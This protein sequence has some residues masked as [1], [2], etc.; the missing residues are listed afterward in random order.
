MRLTSFDIKVSPETDGY[1]HIRIHPRAATCLGRALWHGARSAFEHPRHGS[2]Q[3]MEAYWQW[4]R[5]GKQHDHLRNFHGE[6]AFSVGVR[7]ET[8]PCMNF[9]RQITEGLHHRITQSKRV[10][11]LMLMGDVPFLQYND[12][13]NVGDYLVIHRWDWYIKSLDSIRRSLHK[14]HGQATQP[15]DFK[16]PQIT[17]ESIKG[18]TIAKP[19]P[20]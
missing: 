17:Q 10:V 18:Y 2:F 4:L 5:T 3:S 1:D 20:A 7:H 14:Q 16:I 19:M 12:D 8:V 15:F 9:R 13:A 11:D 6:R